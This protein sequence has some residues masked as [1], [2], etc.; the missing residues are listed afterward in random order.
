MKTLL[1]WL[2]GIL[3]ALGAI[4]GLTANQLAL[5]KVFGPAFE[6]TRR[7]TFEQSKAYRDGAN[8]ELQALRVEYLKAPDELRP[9]MAHMIR[10]KAAG[11]QAGA[12]PSDL[13]T[14]I[15]ELP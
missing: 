7:E 14:F 1:L 12:L 6:Q 4:W 9:A 11:L 10:H 2:G 13:E 5:F 15:K 8:Q 3:L